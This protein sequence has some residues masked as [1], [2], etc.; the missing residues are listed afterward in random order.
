[1]SPANIVSTGSAE[2]PAVK[3]LESYGPIAVTPDRTEDTLI[4]MLTEARGLIVRGD[5]ADVT[6]RVIDAAPKL[7]V[8]GRSGVGYNNVDVEAAT[9][10]KIPLVFTPGAGARAV[11]ESSIAMVLTLCKRLMYW[12]EQLKSGNWDS[13][14]ESHPGDMEG[15]T[16]GIVGFGRIGQ[17]LARLAAPF[18]MTILATDP[19]VSQQIAEERNTTL[20][21]L[22]ELLTRSDFICLHAAAVEGSKGL[23]NRQRL[24]TVKRGACLINL[25]R[26]ELVESLD[27]LHE[28]L[29]DGRLAAVGLDVFAPEPPDVR[30]P[31]FSLSQC[32]TAPHAL[33]MTP[34]AMNRIWTSMARDMD[35]V[36]SGRRPQ[37]VVNEQVL[38]DS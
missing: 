21:D 2:G 35:A 24:E 10:R 13:R 37:F 12:D 38:E 1:M 8:I 9:A 29:L 30:H 27:V 6:A 14:N 32:L 23:I 31:I 3:I 34:G 33:G 25:A 16:L 28:A 15:A 11:A 18:D 36:L 4:A 26:G 22:D 17:D 19:F 20:V 5:G 7:E